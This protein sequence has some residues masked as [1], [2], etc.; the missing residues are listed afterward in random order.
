MM[1][2]VFLVLKKLSSQVIIIFYNII[3]SSFIIAE[4]TCI[5]IFINPECE[6][7]YSSKITIQGS[8]VDEEYKFKDSKNFGITKKNYVRFVET[9]KPVYKPGDKCTILDIKQ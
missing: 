6:I 4:S 9:D 5:D 1:I 3:I 7:T 8:S 2:N